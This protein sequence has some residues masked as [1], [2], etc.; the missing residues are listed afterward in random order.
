[1]NQNDIDNTYR[2]YD[3]RFV[4]IQAEMNTYYENLEN[5]AQDNVSATTDSLENVSTNN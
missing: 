5:T 4:D 2:G 3:E 1:M